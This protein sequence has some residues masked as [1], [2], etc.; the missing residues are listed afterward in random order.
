MK[1][2]DPNNPWR[3]AILTSA[4]GVD[5]VIC[6]ALGYWFGIWMSEL[7]HG[8]E[9]WIL[10]GLITGILL[11]IASTYALVKRYGGTNE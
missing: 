8:S 6:I 5:I 9:V 10:V 4:I 11:S 1:Q 3:G 2:S 7:F